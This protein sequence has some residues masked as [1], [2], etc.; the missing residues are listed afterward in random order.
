MNLLQKK[1]GYAQ[2]GMTLMEVIASLGVLAVVV[3]GALALY[4]SADSSQKSNQM[5][6]DFTS[7]R[8]A[9]KTLYSGQGSYGTSNVNDV[10]V[11]AK[12]VPATMTVDTTTTPDTIN[13][14]L[15]GTVNIAGATSTFTLTA[16]NIPSDVCTNLM[17]AGGGWVS[18]KAGSASARTPPID[19]GTASTDCG[20]AAT[21]TMVFTGN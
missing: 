4:N 14:S 13:H 18:V 7:L 9:M 1:L 19:P 11:T 21:L 12:K 10:L 5:Q 17:T 6:V 15:N 20:A 8:S 3:I 2:K 16:T